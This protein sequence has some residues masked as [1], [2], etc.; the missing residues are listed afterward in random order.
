MENRLKYGL[1]PMALMLLLLGSCTVFK[2]AAREENALLPESY[3]DS[4]NS[5][6]VADLNWREYFSDENLVALIDTAL[7]NNQELNIIL[8]E[9]EIS[10]NEVRARK[11][12]YL[13]F[14]GIGAGAGLEKEGRYTRKGAV[15][16]QLHIKDDKAFPEPLGEFVLGAYASWEVDI[17][18]KLRNAQK[19]AVSRYLA[20]MEGKNFM[21]TNLVAEIAEAYYELTALDNLLEN[22]EQN[23]IIQSNAFKVVRQQKEAA[24]VS[25]LAVNRFKAQLL[26]TQNLQYEIKQ[27]ITETENRINFLT[28]RFPA[29]IARS[30]ATFMDIATD[31]V[32]AGVPSQLLAVRP[33][34]R[35]AEMELAAAKL[36]VSVAK[37]AF[38]PSLD[39]TAAVGF[40]AFNPAFLINPESMLYNLAGDLTAPLINRNALKAAYY[41]AN[42]L[43]LQ[44][45]FNYEQT[46]LNAYLDVLNQL[47]KMNNFHR[48]YETKSEEVEI[49]RQSTHIANSLFNSARADYAEVLLTQREALEATLELIE[50]KTKLLSGKVNIYR[51][52]GGGWN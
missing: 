7:K 1:V 5:T 2:Q 24:K 25:Q 22:I 23:I 52:L 29:P 33:D 18:K 9:I 26:N 37:A 45:V 27:K 12:E 3:F 30:S 43:Q 51:A 11:G 34:I 48:S 32:Q 47:T 4:K 31:S 35:Q 28:A 40:Q 16:E 42:A 17:W 20:S 44:A 50:V 8:Q 14:M 46:V 15:D 13:P 36:D 49:L 21:V 19:A 39:I 41:A 6:N 10:K 38:Y